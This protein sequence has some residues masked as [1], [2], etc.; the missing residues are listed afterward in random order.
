[1]ESS[2]RN[3]LEKFTKTSNDSIRYKERG[4]T[5][6]GGRR[7][8]L[9]GIGFLMQGFRCFPWMAVIFFL[10]DGLRVDPSTLQILQNSAN[11]PMVAKPFYGL[12]SD[13]FY[14]FG[15][16]RIPYIAFGALLQA[17]SWLTIASL[18]SSSM[19]FFTITVYLLLGNLGASI[20]EVANDAV[21]AECGKQS[22]NDSGSSSSDLQSYAWVASSIGGV[23]GNLLGGISITQFSP[24]AMFSFF[25]I[26][27]TL[28]FFITISVSERSLDLPKS[29]SNHGIRK[30]LSELLLVLRKPEIYQPI[31]WFAAS[32]AIIPALTG[33][34]FFYQ[35]QH[36]KIESSVLGISKVFGQ[37]AMLLW[38]VVY[39]QHLKSIPPRK[40]IS[41]I[42]GT[43]AVLMVSD[44]LFVNGF[45][46]TM[47]IPDS[48]Y[49]VVVSG[50]LEVLYFFKTLP[51][52]V[53]MAKLC[54]AGC[55]GSLMA[56]VMSSIALAFIVSGYLGV[57]LG[58]YVEI[59]ET[60]FSGF[61]KGLLIQAAC[62]VLPLFW[63]SVI[64]EYPKLKTQKKEK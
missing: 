36:L 6:G 9:L 56:F 2:S 15:Q 55:E 64:P 1:M 63:S 5:K 40:L 7:E 60:D 34:M 17:V 62:T 29:P 28:Q 22:A 13:S 44:A 16:H 33:T 35:T 53:L 42:Q 47:G 19:S 39:N 45:Y 52:S 14:V 57:A 31:S 25:G 4:R 32:Y 50:L 18:P 11:L 8:M 23:L 48:L 46:R 38:G 24:S 41:M 58:S 37:V 59:T 30:Q 51:F 26:L 27:L 61:Q 3:K 12:L 43:M 20:V 21:V 49:I 54:P 10:K